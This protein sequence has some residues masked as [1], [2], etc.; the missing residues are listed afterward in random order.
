MNKIDLGKSGDVGS[1]MVS[2]VE[3]IV[4]AKTL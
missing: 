2:L 3:S 4:Y 1:E